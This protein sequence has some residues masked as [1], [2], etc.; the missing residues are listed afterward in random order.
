M[1]SMNRTICQ[2][3]KNQFKD[4]LFTTQEFSALYKQLDKSDMQTDI[5]GLQKLYQREPISKIIT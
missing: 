4:L 5:R 2:K 3:I 1:C